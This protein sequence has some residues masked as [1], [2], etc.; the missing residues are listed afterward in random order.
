MPIRPEGQQP[1]TSGDGSG[2]ELQAEYDIGA[3]RADQ[4]VAEEARRT[5]RRQAARKVLRA[6]ATVAESVADVIG[7]IVP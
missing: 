3:N 5:K 7:Q 4:D 1:P 2:E 6:S